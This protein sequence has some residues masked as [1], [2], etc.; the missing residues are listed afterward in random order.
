M[1]VF[2]RRTKTT[3][4]FH[5]LNPAKPTDSDSEASGGN[6]QTVKGRSKSKIR[7]Q[8]GEEDDC[9]LRSKCKAGICRSGDVPS[10]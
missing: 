5:G 8:C 9:P 10:E 1:V 4:K 6:P 3:L 2:K 7:V